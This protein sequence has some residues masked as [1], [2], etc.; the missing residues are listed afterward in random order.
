MLI[1]THAHLEMPDFA[2]DLPAVLDRARAAGVVHIVAA[3]IGLPSLRRGLDL[4]AD[5]PGFITTTAGVH[6][7]DASAVSPHDW[8]E[9]ARL[10]ADPRVVAI[11]ETGLDY[12]RNRAPRN[13]QAE[14]FVRHIELAR[15]LGKPLVV[16]SRD[17][18]ADTFAILEREHAAEAGGVLHCFSGTREDGERARAL[19][20]LPLVAGPL[21][22]P[23]SALRWLRARC[24]SRDGGRDRRPVAR[25]SGAPRQAQRTG[26]RHPDGSRARRAQRSCGARRAAHHHSQRLRPLPAP[27]PPAPPRSPTR[28]A[29]PS[30]ST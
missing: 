8:L 19:G 20:F 5:N 3:S 28:Y 13:R 29:I 9:I 16:H 14:C 17:A 18:S 6:P 22:Y 25:T 23:R 10:A 11:G 27:L 1:D 26:V 21:T 15:A 2:A 30:T 24:R 4:A 12:Y 7:N